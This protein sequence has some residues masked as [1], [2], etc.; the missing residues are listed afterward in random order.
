MKRKV[1][2][3]LFR[4]LLILLDTKPLAEQGPFIFSIQDF[5]KSHNMAQPGILL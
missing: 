1:N 4:E 3:K 2:N 5:L